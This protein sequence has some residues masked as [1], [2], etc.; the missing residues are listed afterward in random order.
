MSLSH[1]NSPNFNKDQTTTKG[2]M[3]DSKG[4]HG[5]DPGSITHVFFEPSH[6][7]VM[8][9]AGSFP[10]TVMREGGDLKKVRNS[11][12]CNQNFTY[13]KFQVQVKCHKIR[14]VDFDPHVSCVFV[15]VRTCA[16]VCESMCL[17]LC[18]LIPF[19]TSTKSW[20]GYIFTAV[21]LCV[22]LC[23]CVCVCLSVCPDFL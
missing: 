4:G 17:V 13:V 11:Y 7:N 20:R 10:V 23:M 16:Y 2:T 6:Y 12:T 1:A 3:D 9:N 18:S 19:Y 14:I 21:C 8:E 5:H 22:S 15:C